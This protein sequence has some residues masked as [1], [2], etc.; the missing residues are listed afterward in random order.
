MA[1]PPVPSV[2]TA[3][4]PAYLA[5]LNQAQ[6][7]AVEAIDGPVLVLAG[8]GTGKTRVLTTRLAH[9]LATRR[10]WPS[11]ILA[12]TFTNRAAREMRERLERIIG[13]NAEGLWLGTFHS[14]AARLLRRHAEVV[15]LKPNFTILDTDDQLRLV[16]QIL[17]A[18][19]VDE[20]RWPARVLLSAFERWKDRGLTADKVPPDD[21]G[22]LA[23]GRA[24]ALFRLYQD[25]LATLNAADFGDLLLHN[26]TILAGR[27]DILA[28]YQQRF[29]YLLVDEYQDTNVAQ[30]LWLRLLAQTKSAQAAPSGGL[31][32]RDASLR[33][34]PQD[35]G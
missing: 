21:R 14:I 19:G 30:Y 16:K 10:A 23:D 12:V 2:A 18:E 1:D 31:I 17:L 33:D 27:A 20:K 22:E 9:I 25:R 7:R 4:P 26:L 5:G 24:L 32:L 3:T 15:G 6:R 34:A 35:E 29:R 11:Q 13:E 28:D 8:A